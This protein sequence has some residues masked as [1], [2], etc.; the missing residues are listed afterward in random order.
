MKSLAVTKDLNLEVVE[1]PVPKCEDNKVLV[2]TLA[3]GVCNGTDT[4]ILHGNFK[5]IDPAEYPCLLGHEGVGEVVEVGKNVTSFEVGDKILLPFIENP[6]EGYSSYWGAYSEYAICGDWKAMA[7]NGQGPGSDAF[8][9]FY[10]TQSKLP[11]DIDPID[12]TMIITF[13]EVLS[14]AKK[15]G[16]GPGKSVAIFGAGPVGLSFAKFAKMLG[17]APIILF[18]IVDEKLEEAKKEG[19]DY[20]FNSTKVNPAEEVRKVCKDGVDFSLDAVGINALINEDMK[21]IK[22]GGTICVYGISPNL[23]VELDWSKAPYN[24]KLNF[25]QFPDKVAEAA[26]HNEIMNWIGLGLLNPRDFISHVIDFKDVL[27]AF[28]IIEKKQPCK[29]IVIR[30]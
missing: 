3:C 7:N 29:K 16:F 27:D 8:G 19:V 13:R 30:Y 1:V 12:A 23:S 5:N 9:E 6:P 24:W 21:L 4:K 14:A 15:F 11:R 28:D 22:D 10:Y 26:A 20:A 18:D 25:Q 2:K 17:M